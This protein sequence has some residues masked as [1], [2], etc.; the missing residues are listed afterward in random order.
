MLNESE[1]ANYDIYDDFELN[2]TLWSPLFILK[3]VSALNVNPL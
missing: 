2:K 1:R 3:I